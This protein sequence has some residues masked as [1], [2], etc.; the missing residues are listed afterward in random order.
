MG[1]FAT[2]GMI[3]PRGLL[4]GLL[5]AFLLTA[6][7]SPGAAQSVFQPEFD[8]EAVAFRAQESTATRLDV[9]TR[10]PYRSL[11]FVRRGD[12]FAGRYTVTASVYRT[13]DRG[14]A[15]RLVLSRSWDRTVNV[16]SY[17]ASQ[18]DT[19]ADLAV[20]A[21]DVPPGR[22]AVTLELRD[23]TSSRTF[24]RELSVEVPRLD[25]AP[26]L[27]DLLLTDEYDAS[28]GT[29]TPAI[30]IVASDQE[31]MTV[32]FEVYARRDERLRARYTV[33]RPGV[34]RR[35]SGIAG[36]LG[37]TERE[38]AE[39]LYELTEW[40]PV[41]V[42]R[43]PAALTLGT[44]RLGA[45]DY[46][47]GVRLEREDGTVV[48]ERNRAFSVRWTG[49]M[50]QLQDL[51]TA[52]AQLRYIA[53]DSEIRAMRNAAS[54]AERMRLFQEFWDRRDPSPGTRRNERMEEYYYRIAYADRTYSRLRNAGW[55]T[56]RGEVFVR[57]GEPDFVESHP[58]NYG[59]KPY[60]VW[61]Y[62][63]IGRRFIFVDESG[64]GEYRLLVPIWDERT[65]M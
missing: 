7:A 31:E 59:T 5:L 24:A 25:Q 29:M 55:S 47:L 10:V 50:D 63:R 20:Q 38:P 49:L 9:Y 15:E 45:G 52:I 36:L 30:G 12:G 62:E 3:P 41:R 64:F 33:Q 34:E 6:W 23:G 4:A 39:S 40:L 65:R 19:R 35:R 21:L 2:T 8:A 57:F 1:C 13:D 27:S 42:G 54:P 61:Y 32:Y 28:A 51:D 11:R 58:F 18:D 26:A 16:A 14:R 44:D 56:D 17:D 53:R 43:N 48:A 22:Y 46:V 60:Q 37:R